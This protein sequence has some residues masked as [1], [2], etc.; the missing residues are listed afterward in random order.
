MAGT[1]PRV[2]LL[3][4]GA[5]ALCSAAVLSLASV[6]CARVGPPRD[7]KKRA[8]D[9]V[10]LAITRDFGTQSVLLKSP[11][12]PRGATVLGVL[13]KNARVK[14]AYGGGF[15]NSIQGLASGYTKGGGSKYDW[16]YYVNGVQASV[17]AGEYQLTAGDRVWWDYHNWNFASFVPAVIGQYPEPFVHGHGGRRPPVAVVYAKG[18]EH[19]A[20]ALRDRLLRDGAK[21][22]TFEPL[23]SSLDAPG[24]RS[25]VLIGVWSDLARLKWVQ[26]AAAA[27]STSGVFVR[28]EKGEALMLD[29]TG[30]TS[31]AQRKAGAIMATGQP[32]Q[33]AVAWLVTGVDAAGVQRAAQVLIKT[34]RAINGKFGVV[35]DEAGNIIP[36][37]RAGG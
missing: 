5:L 36:V 33:A 17:G 25:L 7:A 24:A 1:R 9:T 35:V 10:R 19:E 28:F 23:K 18:F 27:P 21:N 8:T 30:T 13:S 3:A 31:D 32:G 12:L 11:R 26:E 22:V 20:G 34:P 37:P 15:V 14:T 4:G 2:R 6:G 29:C 16:F